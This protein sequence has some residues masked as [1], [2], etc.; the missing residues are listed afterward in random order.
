MFTFRIGRNNNSNNV[1]R[2]DV[3]NQKKTFA[4]TNR[5]HFFGFYFANRHKNRS[6]NFSGNDKLN[7]LPPQKK[8]ITTK[9]L[10]YKGSES[11]SACEKFSCPK[12]STTRTTRALI[13]TKTTIINSDKSNSQTSNKTKKER[14][15]SLWAPQASTPPFDATRPHNL[16]HSKTQIKKDIATFTLIHRSPFCPPPSASAE[17]DS[18][19]LPVL[20]EGSRNKLRSK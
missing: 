7:C 14:K 9:V 20:A 3:E 5:F 2:P 4:S 8:T 1:P 10:T 13:A 6:Q 16:V 17:L 12:I 11:Q 19:S 15:V 18:A